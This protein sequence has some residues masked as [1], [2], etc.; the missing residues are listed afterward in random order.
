MI[1]KS[2]PGIIPSHINQF[3]FQY[4]HLEFPG[5]VPRT[6]VGAF[7]VAAVSKPA[8]MVLQMIDAPKGLV[9]IMGKSFIYITI[10]LD[11][12]D[13]F[14]NIVSGIFR[15]GN[16]WLSRKNVG[17]PFYV[18]VQDCTYHMWRIN[19]FFQLIALVLHENGI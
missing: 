16:T 14:V 15:I 4:D 10:F 6:F 7:A 18:V 12:V 17:P 11:I 13:M 1:H 8:Q 3:L 2:I 19:T 5:V 9:L